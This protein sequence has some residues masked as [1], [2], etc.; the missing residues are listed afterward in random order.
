MAHRLML[1]WYKY[2]NK[3]ANCILCDCLMAEPGRSRRRRVRDG[4]GREPEHTP[5]RWYIN[6][7]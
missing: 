1:Y 4:G 6:I 3:Q 2:W 7:S 5:K